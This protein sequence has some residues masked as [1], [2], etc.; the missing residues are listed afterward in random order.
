MGCSDRGVLKRLSGEQEVLL[1]KVK[2]MS[3]TAFKTWDDILAEGIEQ[4]IEQGELRARRA[5]L[6]RV[7]EKHFPD[8]SQAVLDR[9]DAID[10]P[11]RLAELF[12]RALDAKS[13]D[14]LAL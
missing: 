7:L 11:A 13:L 6:K 2:E 10:D 4:G 9:I 1:Q 3:D 14:E 8:V 5:L 12:D